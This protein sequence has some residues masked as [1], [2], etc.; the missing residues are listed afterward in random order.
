MD[1]F[2]QSTNRGVRFRQRRGVAGH[3]HLVPAPLPPCGIGRILTFCHGSHQFLP[4]QGILVLILD[5]TDIVI[6]EKQHPPVRFGPDDDSHCIPQPADGWC[7]SL[8]SR[9]PRL[10]TQCPRTHRG[11]RPDRLVPSRPRRGHP[12]LAR[13]RWPR[14]GRGMTR[15]LTYRARDEA[16]HG[17]FSALL[18]TSS[19]TRFK[20]GALGFCKPLAWLLRIQKSVRRAANARDRPRRAGW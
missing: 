6:V 15:R 14:G 2:I 3:F 20:G 11:R 17:P 13:C 7:A 8:N 12:Q 4:I 19:C 10:F 16:R 18:C 9:F 5:E 1:R